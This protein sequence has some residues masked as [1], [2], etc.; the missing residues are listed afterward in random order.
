MWSNKGS[1]GGLAPG[2]RT[3]HFS[4]SAKEKGKAR[5]LGAQ[6]GSRGDLE[7]LRHATRLTPRFQRPEWPRAWVGVN[8]VVNC[9]GGWVS[10]GGP[11]QRSAP[12]SPVGPSRPP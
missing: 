3:C 1:E 9:A 4:C 8:N 11:R 10:V 12:C 6:A 7:F 5:G 2:R